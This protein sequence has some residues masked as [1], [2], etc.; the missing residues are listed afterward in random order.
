MCNQTRNSVPSHSRSLPSALP[1]RGEI[2]NFI[3]V[4]DLKN[5]RNH[6]QNS[7]NTWCEVFKLYKSIW[8]DICKHPSLI[9]VFMRP[10][11]L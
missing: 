5:Y 6:Y 7:L 9:S 1:I 8:Q 10:F 11:N 3:S 4:F 2:V